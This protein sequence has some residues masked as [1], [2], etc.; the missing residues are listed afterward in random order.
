MGLNRAVRAIRKC[1]APGLLSLL[2]GIYC[3]IHL[4]IEET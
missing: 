3:L 4:E 1:Y 2:R